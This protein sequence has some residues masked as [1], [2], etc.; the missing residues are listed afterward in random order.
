MLLGRPEDAMAG[1]HRPLG[2]L[3]WLAMGYSCTKRKLALELGSGR[4]TSSTI[5]HACNSLSDIFAL[6]PDGELA[7]D[8]NFG[9]S[10]RRRF[11]LRHGGVHPSSTIRSSTA[12]LLLLVGLLL[13]LLLAAAAAA[14]SAIGLSIA[15]SIGT[16]LLPAVLVA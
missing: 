5:S 16:L 2:L 3:L 13:L 1:V 11:R 7:V 15:I 9:Q 14:A 10:D 12:S 8:V 6:L 4:P